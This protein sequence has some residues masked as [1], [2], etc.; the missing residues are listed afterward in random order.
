M[1]RTVTLFILFALSPNKVREATEMVQGTQKSIKIDLNQFKLR[2][3]LKPEVEL[4]LHFDSPSRRFYL[5]VIGLVVYEMKKRGRITSIPLQK[6]H[7]I[8]TLLNQ[9]VGGAAGSSNKERLL[10]RIYRKWKDALPDLENAPLFK[11]IGRKKRY[12]ELMDKVYGFSEG[13]KDSWANLFEY[14]GSHENVRLRF[15]IDRLEACLDDVI[16]IFGEYPELAN[17]VAWEGFI[18]RLEEELEDKSRT[19]PV[20]RELKEPESLLLQ[21]RRRMSA[22]PSRWQ[23]PALFVLFA[24]IVGAAAFAVWKY[25]LFAPQDEVASVEKMAFPLPD[26]PSIAVLAFDNMSGDQKL[27]YIADGITENI[28]TTLSKVHDLFVI[29][30]NSSFTYKGKPVKVKQVSE[31]LGVRYVL[32]GSVQRSGDRLRVMAQL[33]D[34]ISGKHMWSERYDR[35]FKEIF[36][37][38]DELAS[39]V[40]NSLMVKLIYGEQAK[41]WQKNRPSNLQFNEKYYEARFYLSQF[42]KE[43]NIKAKQLFKE[44]INLEPEYYRPY[45]GLAHVYF[46]DVHLGLSKSPRESLREAF[47]LCKKAIT[48]DETQDFPHSLLGHIYSLGR[49]FDK[50]IAEGELAIALNPNSARAYEFLGRTLMYA[51]RPVEALDLIKKGVRLKPLN[52]CN[53]TLGAAY[54]E[55]GQYEEALTEFKKCIKHTPNNIIAHSQVADIYARTGRYK[56]ARDAWS[57][58]LKIDPKMTAEKILPKR[59]PYGPEHRERTIATMREAGIK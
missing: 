31:E 25:N 23:W 28:I 51:G 4:T 32:E 56:E 7:K 20:N 5:S 17:E 53:Q 8:L 47:K 30:R 36:E 46:M 42:N 52:L 24:L 44:A 58:V 59:W 54:R 48:L 45:A 29:S 22:I 21:L 1:V 57:E 13:E 49:K 10:P 34:A 11:V 37:L 50:A 39:K 19:E 9:T 35:D 15:S 18:A 41:L 6:H 43:A 38:Q 2:L 14:K 3:Y 26:K 55:V 40:V 16:I 33:I 27:E 12:D